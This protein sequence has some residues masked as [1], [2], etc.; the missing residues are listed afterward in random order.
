MKT[1]WKVNTNFHLLNFFN[2]FNTYIFIVIL[3]F[4][5]QL[6]GEILNFE[7]ESRNKTTTLGQAYDYSSVMH[8]SENGS[9]K[10]PGLRTIKPLKKIAGEWPK[11]GSEK[12]LS[13]GDVVTANRL[14]NCSGLYHFLLY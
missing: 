10:R 8:Y 2:Y 12:R 6:I 5:P 11:M 13:R 7:K 3:I 1:L 9:A 14:Y 4:I